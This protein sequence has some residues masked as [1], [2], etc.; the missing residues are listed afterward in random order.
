MGKS[1]WTHALSNSAARE[2]AAQKYGKSDLLRIDV[3]IGFNGSDKLAVVA[4]TRQAVREA[5]L[6][7]FLSDEIWRAVVFRAACDGRRAGQ[8][9]HLDE[10]LRLLKSNPRLFE[11]TVSE[12]DDE[13]MKAGG[14]LLIVFDALDRLAEDWSQIRD[15][16]TSLMRQALGLKSFR[17]LRMKIFIRPDQFSDPA[18]FHFPDGSKLKNEHVDLSW[19]PHELYGLLFFEIC[20]SES[21]R[22][23]L[24]KLA[25]ANRAESAIH[26]DFS[27]WSL[28]SQER[29]V[30]ALAGAYMGAD[31]RRGRLYTWVPLHLSDANNECSPRTFLTAWQKAA[32]FEPSPADRAI[33]HLG[34]IEGVR[35]ASGARL[36]ELREDY[37]WIDL[38]LEALQGL[39][40]PMERDELFAA[41]E[42]AEVVRKILEQAKQG[43]YLPP[44]ELDEFTS[45]PS[46]LLQALKNIAVMEERSNGKINV[47]D[48]FRV[49][50][51][52][53][54]KGGVAV[55]RKT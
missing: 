36:D 19:K 4:P 37:R 39:F 47:P 52:I 26:F 5:L 54:R 22:G 24:S 30:N 48:I 7:G 8:S 6:A 23:E 40:V 15:L 3:K 14:T 51:G 17:S 33:N 21:A 10:S 43:R 20:R 42:R 11:E 45:S 13:L 49:E 2:R 34:L 50:A 38:A 18:T 46:N 31:A 35:R 12:I 53:K 55:P 16:T 27:R 28:D 44:A 1:F 41:W 29:L 25:E 32:A 9:L